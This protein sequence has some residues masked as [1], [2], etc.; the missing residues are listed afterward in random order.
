MRPLYSELALVEQAALR[1]GPRTR[2]GLQ[3]RGLSG[4]R[5]ALVQEISNALAIYG[6]TTA[7]RGASIRPEIEAHVRDL[8][9]HYQVGDQSGMV[10]PS[11]EATVERALVELNPPWYADDTWLGVV[12][13]GVALAVGLGA[14]ALVGGGIYW[15][16]H[17]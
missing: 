14:V 12:S 16:K 3:L 17:R 13:N 1:R 7:Y 2:D 10:D 15:W 6:Q 11:E 5:Q 8:L 4:T 9:S